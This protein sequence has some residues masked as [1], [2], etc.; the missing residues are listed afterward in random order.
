MNKRVCVAMFLMLVLFSSTMIEQVECV[1]CQG[2]DQGWDCKQRVPIYN[3]NNKEFYV[4]GGT[5][6]SGWKP[7]QHRVMFGG[8]F[9]F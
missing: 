1:E 8:R 7:Q 3:D 9:R 6:G 4:E 5:S 2:S